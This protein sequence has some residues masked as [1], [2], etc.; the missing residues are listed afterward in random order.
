[1]RPMNTWHSLMKYVDMCIHG[2]LCKECC[3]LWN[4][5]LDKD[6][7]GKGTMQCKTV[8]AHR[9]IYQGKRNVILNKEQLV[10]HTCDIRNCCNWNH[11]YVG[12]DKQNS[13]DKIAR[14]RFVLGSRVNLPKGT[15]QVNSKL[16]EEQVYQMRRSYYSGYW[17]QADLVQVFKVGKSVVQRILA[18]QDW[19]HLQGQLLLS[20]ATI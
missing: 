4:T 5:S 9:S 19:H 11:L 14:G 7:Y 16:T 2:D 1:M 15:Q 17:T 18:H 6:G 3:W 13:D 20:T 8:I 12:N 10:L